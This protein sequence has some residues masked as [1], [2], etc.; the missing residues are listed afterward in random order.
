VSARITM[1]TNKDARVWLRDNGYIEIADQIDAIMEGWRERDVKTRRNWWDVLAGNREGRA[2]KIEGIAFPVLAAA[3][4]RKGWPSCA[5]EIGFGEKAPKL[6]GVKVASPKRGAP[7][8]KARANGKAA[9]PKRGTSVAK[10]A[11]SKPVAKAA[12]SKSVAKAASPQRRSLASKALKETSSTD[13]E[14]R[15]ESDQIQRHPS[16]TRGAISSTG[17]PSSIRQLI[18]PKRFEVLERESTKAG[19]DVKDVVE[20]VDDAARRVQALLRKVRDSGT[21]QFEIFFGESGSGK[22]TFLK[23]LPKFFD[24]VQVLTILESTPLIDI[25]STIEKLSAQHDEGIPVF[26]VE[27]R[28]NARI[29]KTSAEDFFEALRQLFRKPDG[30]VLV[31]WPV[32]KPDTRDRLKEIAWETGAESIVPLDTRGVYTFTGLQR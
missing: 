15:L 10:A 3:R 9:S 27:N 14:N 23:T 25:P 12:T 11:P 4:R 26:V 16:R 13:T 28:D 8:A 19:V 22:T 18:L 24:G 6:K 17:I 30:R 7:Q 21:G 29:E 31:I 20:R 2:Y 1:T 32:T 5:S